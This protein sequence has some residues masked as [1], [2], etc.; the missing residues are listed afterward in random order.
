MA[1]PLAATG[2]NMLVGVLAGGL[3][4]LAMTVVQRI[5]AKLS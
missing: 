2:L 1:Q 5:K 4:V 3:A